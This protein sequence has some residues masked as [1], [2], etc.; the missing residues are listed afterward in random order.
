MQDIREIGKFAQELLDKMKDKEMPI[1]YVA[2][3]VKSAL[4]EHPRDVVLQGVASVINGQLQ[5][6]AFG[7]ITQSEMGN[8]YN[9][10]CV[11]N[12]DNKFK[13]CLADLISETPEEEKRSA[14]QSRINYYDSSKAD[15]PVELFNADEH[16]EL[17]GIFDKHNI[18]SAPM[19]IISQQV[20]KHLPQ[21]KEYDKTAAD[22]GKGLVEFCFKVAG[23][24]VQ[25]K[26]IIGDKDKIVYCVSLDTG[27]KNHY[28]F[29]P[30]M[31]KGADA[32]WPDHFVAGEE[33]RPITKEAVMDYI[34]DVN[35]QEPDYNRMFSKADM[36]SDKL[37][38]PKPLKILTATLEE[39]L[40]EIGTSFDRNVVIK[41]KDA[42]RNEIESMG[43]RI[44]DVRVASE[45]D[46]GVIYSASI[47]NVDGS[48]TVEVP[49]EFVEDKALIPRFFAHGDDFRDLTAANIQSVIKKSAAGDNT[50]NSY[51]FSMNV[52]DMSYG[53]LRDTM[54]YSVAS[55]DYNKAEEVLQFVNHKFGSD[56]YK[57]MFSDYL[58]AMKAISKTASLDKCKGCPYFDGTSKYHSCGYC[59]K[60][61]MDASKVVKTASGCLRYDR[62]TAEG[63]GTYLNQGTSIKLGDE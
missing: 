49:V 29:V 26:D 4:N 30:T 54:L 42:V 39:S 55:K 57:N 8:L 62:V 43:C 56:R 37:D 10:L 15:K 53:E 11:L 12:R 46:D 21:F 38:L 36:V 51:E 27:N 59:V 44:K 31:I 18:D 28:L 14:E 40:A 16:Q 47:F 41:G 34:N 1:D 22:L 50:K 32:Q 48:T 19:D 33:L 17:N 45:H 13:E 9:D 20:E 58:S 52:A 23:L 60:L 5:K 2:K 7:V 3:R 35:R 63:P 25:A 61:G 6:N 24:K